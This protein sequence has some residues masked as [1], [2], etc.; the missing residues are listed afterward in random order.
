M[1]DAA[2]AKKE[3]PQS[4]EPLQDCGGADRDTSAIGAD[5]GSGSAGFAAGGGGQDCPRRAGTV[6]RMA[7]AE[8]RSEG[9][10]IA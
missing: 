4:Q 7:E 2:M 9:Q 5:S 10:V 3:E 1:A 8:G 6:S